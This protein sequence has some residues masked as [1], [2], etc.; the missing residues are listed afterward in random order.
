MKTTKITKE[1]I[2]QAACKIANEQGLKQVTVRNVA[3]ACKVSIGSVYNNYETKG[4]L[5]FDVAKDYWRSVFDT[6]VLDS[7]PKDD[8]CDFCGAL[9]KI[10]SHKLSGFMREWISV[11]STFSDEDKSMGR[12]KEAEIF[13]GFKILLQKALDNDKKINNQV[14]ENDFSKEEMLNFI[15]TNMLN[16]LRQGAKNCDFLI[17]VLR[18]ALY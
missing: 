8:F 2:F 10:L 11:M 5:V 9:Y 14:W 18:K 3:A 7:L 15:F 17:K 16:S 6:A 1:Q 12:A 13:S 4:E